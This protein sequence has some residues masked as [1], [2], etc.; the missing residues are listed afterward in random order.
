MGS[1]ALGTSGS[2]PIRQR[3]DQFMITNNWTR[4]MGTHTL[5]AGVDI[6]RGRENRTESFSPRTGALTF[7]AGPTSNNGVGGLGLAS[8]MLGDVTGFARDVAQAAPKEAMWRTFYYA[9]DTWRATTRLTVNIGLRWDIYFPETV[10]GVGRGALLNLS[11][12]DLQVVRASWRLRPGT[13]GSSRLNLRNFGPR[14]GLSYQLDSKT[15][16]RA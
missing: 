16:V 5:K 15:V 11:T 8:F 2:T 13:W 10:D 3:E 6:R 7:G 14:V 9:Q 1:L 4:I 12:G